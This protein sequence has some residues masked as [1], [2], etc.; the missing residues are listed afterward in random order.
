MS[1]KNSR[2]LSSADDWGHE[3]VRD[4]AWRWLQGV[5]AEWWALA[6]SP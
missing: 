5:W 2:L 3:P 6:R 1:W 4:A